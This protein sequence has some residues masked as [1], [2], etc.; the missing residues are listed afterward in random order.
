VSTPAG[1]ATPDAAPDAEVAPRLLY[2]LARLSRASRE[3]AEE[4]LRPFNLTAPQYAALSMLA[5]RS[6]LSNAQL[7]RRCYVTPQSM[8]EVILELERRDLIRR[9][10]DRLNKRILRTVL[11]TKGR[12]VLAACDAAV[13]EVEA[14]MLASLPP[15]TRE[16]LRDELIECVHNLGAGL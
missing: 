12:E 6:G 13:D 14:L 9:A 5:A 4:R 2:V 15:E 3:K 8:S 10:P 16:R 11:T 1:A 7:A